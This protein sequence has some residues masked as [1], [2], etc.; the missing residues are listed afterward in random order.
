MPV[1]ITAS[2]RCR[3]MIISKDDVN[4][5]RNARALLELLSKE[6]ATNF[7]TPFVE[8][9]SNAPEWSALWRKALIRW[10]AKFVFNA[11]L[12]TPPLVQKVPSFLRFTAQELEVG[13]VANDLALTEKALALVSNA[14]GHEDVEEGLFLLREIIQRPNLNPEV[15]DLGWQEGLEAFFNVL[16]ESTKDENIFAL[17]LDT[18][19]IAVSQ[20]KLFDD[21][22]D[23]NL[24]QWLHSLITD[25]TQAIWKL[26]NQRCQDY[27]KADTYDHLL[28]SLLRFVSSTVLL[29][30]VYSQP[31]SLHHIVQILSSTLDQDSQAEV[32]QLSSLKLLLDCLVNSTVA[33]YELDP[34]SVDQAMIAGLL[35]NTTATTLSFS[36]KSYKNKGRSI[37]QS[38]SKLIN[39]LVALSKKSCYGTAL[40]S[41]E[42]LMTLLRHPD[43][44]VKSI[45]LH[46]CTHVSEKVHINDDVAEIALSILFNLDETCFVFEQAC[47]LVSQHAGRM[48]ESAVHH[49]V[50]VAST[51][52]IQLNQTLVSAICLLLTN[53]LNKQDSLGHST[54]ILNGFVPV[55]PSYLSSKDAD[56]ETKANMFTLLIRVA[57]LQPALTQWLITDTSCVSAAI[58]SLF[59]TEEKLVSEAALLLCYLL[60]AER[61]RSS[62]VLDALLLVTPDLWGVLTFLSER[63]FDSAPSR[64]AMA[65]V[66][67]LL[68]N[69]LSAEKASSLNLDAKHVECFTKFVLDNSPVKAEC[70]L[71]CKALEALGLLF[72]CSPD[73][74]EDTVKLALGFI[75]KELKL[76]S[77]KTSEKYLLSLIRLVHNFVLPHKKVHSGFL[78]RGCLVYII[79]QWKIRSSRDTE[80]PLLLAIIDLQKA[81][82]SDEKAKEVQQLLKLMIEF[83]E[84]KESLVARQTTPIANN[85]WI[86][87]KTLHELLLVSAPALEF[88]REIAKYKFLNDFAVTWHP[89]YLKRIMNR[90][91]NATWSTLRGLRMRLLA[92]FTIFTEPVLPELLET[93]AVETI[94]DVGSYCSNPDDNVLVILRNISY[95]SAYRGTLIKASN[96]IPFLVRVISSDSSC[97]KQAC[98]ELALATLITL[99][100][101]SPKLRQ[102]T[103]SSTE[104]WLRRHKFDQS[105]VSQEYS[106][107]Y[108]KFKNLMES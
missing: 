107:L 89:I 36:S 7:P 5:R 84:E 43:P 27:N 35:K 41:Q 65:F 61:Q 1:L 70:S 91:Q 105:K 88:R 44:V 52:R 66:E 14:K 82:A 24:Y 87:I 50:K 95:H 18:I 22:P 56:T 17:I 47:L 108:C 34:S 13:A 98:H 90:Q 33:A 54:I 31:V 29:I 78:Q 2:F 86:L 101:E 19:M 99:C 64:I 77:L 32:Y 40:P 60:H 71:R 16:P 11:E 72:F 80:T 92:G 15:F 21:A 63:T 37:I 67:S 62:N 25:S 6:E 4:C 57:L 30:A 9:S 100:C 106:D 75:S 58:V 3:A 28:P 42:W 73:L 20:L 74:T 81:L 53:C 10:S 85:D 51:P 104:G 26:F 49:L 45:G 55:I 93:K 23:Y 48:N 68:V 103:R 96:V 83:L 46:V 59:A 12:S 97:V 102:E 39:L 94:V 69:A 76:V 79:E 38:C 8:D